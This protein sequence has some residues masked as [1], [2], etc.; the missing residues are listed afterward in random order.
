MALAAALTSGNGGDS[1]DAKPLLSSNDAITGYNAVAE[2]DNAANSEVGS[3]GGSSN[4]SSAFEEHGTSPT[5]AFL[6]LVK[7]YFGAGMLR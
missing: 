2:A 3:I 6:N 5:E 1:T 7:G 4:S